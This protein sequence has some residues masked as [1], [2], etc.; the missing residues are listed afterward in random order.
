MF[1]SISKTL[2]SLAATAL[3]PAINQ[4]KKDL[5]IPS[6]G[7]I[8]V[9]DIPA[10]LEKINKYPWGKFSNVPGLA[11]WIENFKRGLAEKL[12]EA[13]NMEARCLGRRRYRNR[14]L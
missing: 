2:T 3:Q 4:I 7:V 9:Q 10:I 11:D 6:D 12:S 14:I 13:S 5:G 8:P 1:S